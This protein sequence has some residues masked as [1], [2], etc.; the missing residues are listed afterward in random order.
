MKIYTKKEKHS[1]NRLE[2]Q[3]TV[4]HNFSP[5]KHGIA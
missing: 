4:K 5:Q 3:I 2:Q 1:L